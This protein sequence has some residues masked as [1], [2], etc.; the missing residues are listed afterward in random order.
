MN[1][2]SDIEIPGSSQSTVERGERGLFKDF[3]P[4]LVFNQRTLERMKK[5]E[6][7][8]RRGIAVHYCQQCNYA[9][10]R[11]TDLV[12]HSRTH[13]GERPYECGICDEKFRQ[14][15]VLTQHLLTHQEGRFECDECHYKATKKCFT[16]YDSFRSQ[17][18][19]V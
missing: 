10:K 7:L 1:F 16:S 14:K 11:K 5:M 3:I 6:G 15:G 17:A 8:R 19:Q 18:S 4:V 12:K 9:T 13:S 2:E